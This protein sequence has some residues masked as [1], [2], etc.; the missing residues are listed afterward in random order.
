MNPYF[1]TVA[2]W[3]YGIAGFGYAVFAL[4]LRFGLRGGLRGLALLTAVGLTAAWAFLQLAFALTHAPVY[5][6][7]GAVVDVLRVGAWF[8]F[9]LLLIERGGGSTAPVAPA[10]ASRTTWLLPVAAALVILGVVAQCAVALGLRVFGDPGRL[11]LF[12]SL[13]LSIFGLMLVE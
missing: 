5:F 10:G 9:L 4:Y 8:A 12:D 1:T 3:S 6:A 2:A 11:A 7:F 13:A